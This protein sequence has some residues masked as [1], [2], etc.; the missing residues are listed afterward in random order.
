[1]TILNIFVFGL[2]PLDERIALWLYLKQAV[3]IGG[4]LGIGIGLGK[5]IGDYIFKEKI[6]PL[7]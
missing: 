5:F 2:Y 1:M 7:S 4:T 6:T 3:K